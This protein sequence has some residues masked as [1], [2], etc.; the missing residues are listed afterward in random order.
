MQF[1]KAVI[2]LLIVLLFCSLSTVVPLVL[3]G[4]SPSWLDVP[5]AIFIGLILARAASNSAIK[6]KY[7]QQLTVSVPSPTSSNKIMPLL[8]NA[9]DMVIVKFLMKHGKTLCK[10][11]ETII[12]YYGTQVYYPT[13]NVFLFEHHLVK[14]IA[15]KVSASGYDLF[16]EP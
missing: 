8:L 12:K 9:G 1:S 11:D 16:R 13:L 14:P 15:I 6:K 5:V 4:A 10:K 2:T 7:S 3:A